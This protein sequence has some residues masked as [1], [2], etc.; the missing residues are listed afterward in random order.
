[1]YAPH[2][3]IPHQVKYS[4]ALTEKKRILPTYFVP[5]PSINLMWHLVFEVGRVGRVGEIVASMYQWD[6]IHLIRTA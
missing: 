1:M 6:R 4:T 5:G 3:T 2:R